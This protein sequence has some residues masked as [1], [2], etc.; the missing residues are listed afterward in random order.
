M[1]SALFSPI[2][3]ADLTIPNRIVVSP[4][5]QYSANDGVGNDWHMTHLGM[6]ANSGA[7]LLVL[8]ATHVERHGRITHGC[9]GIY[10]DDCEGALRRIVLHCKRI[11]T[12]KMGIQLA[13]AGRKASSQRPWE[14]AKALGPKEDPWPTIAPSALPFGPGWHTPRAMNEEDMARVR[15]DF[16]DSAKRAVRVGFDA[17]ELHLAHGYLLH[18]FVSPLSNKRNDEYGGSLAG[19]MRYPLEVAGAVRA[20]LPAGMPLGA[21]ITGTDWLDGGLTGDDAAEFAKAL[22]QA[23]LDYVDISSGNITYESRAPSDPGYNVPIAEKVR[24]ESGIA[25][26]VVGMIENPKQAE[27]IIAEGRADMVALARGFLDDPHWG[28]H[29]AQM[30]GADVARPVQYARAAPTLWPGAALRG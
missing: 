9:L 3:L 4:M 1:P 6:L 5:C 30:L 17:I 2:K 25:V 21:R 24:R 29:A 26:R 27:A 23:G 8:E 20:A 18:S 12:A 16:V 28:W 14:G 13:H 19:R 7:G 10:S 22:K 15:D 11:G